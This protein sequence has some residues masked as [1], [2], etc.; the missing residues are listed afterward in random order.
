[1]MGDLHG[2]LV[3]D[4]LRWWTPE[5]KAT[6]ALR[7]YGEC[8]YCELVFAGVRDDDEIEALIQQAFLA[9]HLEYVAGRSIADPRKFAIDFVRA[10]ARLTID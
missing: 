1:M 7:R 8:V 10:E 2:R 4:R 6:R 3:W 9:L 5:A